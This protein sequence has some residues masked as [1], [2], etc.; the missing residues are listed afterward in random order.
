MTNAYS[1]I[2]YS[3]AIGE[4]F[5]DAVAV[6][7][8]ILYMM[9]A[10]AGLGF[11]YML[12]IRILGGPII[13]ISIFI[14]LLGL[15]YAGFYCFNYST[16]YEETDNM[17]KAY[18][19]GSYVIWGL[20]ACLVCCICCYR[21]ALRLAISIFQVTADFISNTMR[22][23]FVPPLFFVLVVAW[24]VAWTY[25]AAWVW[26]VGEP[27]PRE[28]YPFLTEI[29][30][31]DETRYVFLYHLFGFL[32]INAFLI[33]LCQFTLAVTCCTWYFTCNSDTKGSGSVST[34]F[35]WTFRYHL[36]SIAFGSFIIAVVQMIRIIFEYYKK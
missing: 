15:A 33:G 35:Y 6:Y 26:S 5:A 3:N 9:L 7:D 27:V 17:Y 8:L 25:S 13:Y 20:D 14:I 19:Y 18:L 36:G 32:W 12:V 31:T 4:A 29:I 2:F 23:L 30:W 11:V 10:A 22:V 24:F 21:Q 16:N 1:E 28:D 34:G